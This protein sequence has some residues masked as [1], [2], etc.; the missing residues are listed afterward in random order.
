MAE[1]VIDELMTESAFPHPVTHLIK[2]ET[3]ISWVIL[4]GHYAYKIKK[5]VRLDFIDCSAL[6]TRQRMCEQE[7]TLNRRLAPDLYLGVVAS[8]R[9]QVWSA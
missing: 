4:T 1:L 9:K 3:H 8:T 2:R 7:V 6:S 5:L